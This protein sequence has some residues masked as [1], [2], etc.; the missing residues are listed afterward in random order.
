M[1][2]SVKTHTHTCSQFRNTGERCKTQDAERNWNWISPIILI[3]RT[4]S[5]TGTY[6]PCLYVVILSTCHNYRLI[7]SHH[8]RSPAFSQANLSEKREE[9][10]LLLRCHR[11]DHHQDDGDLCRDSHHPGQHFNGI[12]NTDFHS[13]PA[14]ISIGLV[15]SLSQ[16]PISSTCSFIYF[17]LSCQW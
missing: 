8:A 3:L 14:W 9:L 1:Q 4:Q 13:F 17:I 10:M 12:N 5:V 11:H 6:K 15:S 2:F 16:I 7:S